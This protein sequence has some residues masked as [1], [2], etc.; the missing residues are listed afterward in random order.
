MSLL[1]H[2][3]PLDEKRK[4]EHADDKVLLCRNNRWLSLF[5]VTVP[6]AYQALAAVV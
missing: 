6:F 5:V 3:R 1:A 4:R 2:F